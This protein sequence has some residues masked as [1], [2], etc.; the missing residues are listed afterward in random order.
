[1]KITRRQLRKIIKE[2]ITLSQGPA[3]EPIDAVDTSGESD[4]QMSDDIVQ[5][6]LNDDHDKAML[7]FVAPLLIS[8]EDSY[9]SDEELEMFINE[10]IY[11]DQDV[12]SDSKDQ[13]IKVMMFAKDTEQMEL[14]HQAWV[15]LNEINLPLQDY[16]VME[17]LSSPSIQDLLRQSMTMV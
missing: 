15:E 6:D 13:L 9:V 16:Q 8:A 11:F 10:R 2:E 14:A 1:M 3:D 7:Y 4:L 5:S 12:P 17:I